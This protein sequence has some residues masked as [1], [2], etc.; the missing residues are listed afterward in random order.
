MT[1][2]D[3]KLIA[4]PQFKQWQKH[5]LVELFIDEGEQ[6][7]RWTAKGRKYAKYSTLVGVVNFANGQPL[8]PVA[9]D[10]ASIEPLIRKDWLK[11]GFTEDAY[12][13]VEE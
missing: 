1:K 12:L 11:D 10:R 8:Y 6:F 2:T 9:Y 4:S 7:W 3:K 13:L 5:G